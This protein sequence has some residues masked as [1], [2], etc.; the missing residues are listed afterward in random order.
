MAA[1]YYVLMSRELIVVS[2]MLKHFLTISLLLIVVQTI[3]TMIYT[4]L[5]PGFEMNFDKN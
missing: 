4:V 5:T 3:F 1:K 2:F